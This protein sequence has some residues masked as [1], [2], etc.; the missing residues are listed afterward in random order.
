MTSPANTA[1]LAHLID[2]RRRTHA[3]SDLLTFVDVTP[4]GAYALE[5]RSYEQL[6]ANGQR[7]AAGL[8]GEGQRA[9]DAF[10]IILQNHPE[11]VDAMSARRSPARCSCRSIRARGA[12][13]SPTC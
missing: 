5:T 6:W 7:V 12:R 2:A 8:A 4:D 1:I 13:S 9:G 10:A 11:F 3:V